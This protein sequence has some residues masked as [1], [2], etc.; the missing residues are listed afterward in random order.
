MLLLAAL[1]LAMLLGFSLPKLL[2]ANK[3]IAWADTPT[4]IFIPAGLG[5]A[6]VVRATSQ[7]VYDYHT[8]IDLDRAPGYYP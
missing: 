6:T 5:D 7:A 3:T 1:V 8:I 4:T 2:A